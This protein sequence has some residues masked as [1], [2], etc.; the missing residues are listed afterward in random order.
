MSSIFDNANL[1]VTR[2]S[3]AP[4]S[5]TVRNIDIMSDTMLANQALRNI[6]AK[7]QQI[8]QE[9]NE[10]VELER[11]NA[12]D[13]INACYTRELTESQFVNAIDTY[14]KTCKE[15]CFKTI[16]T[17]LYA[18]SLL[19]DDDFVTEH[20][21]DIKTLISD[22]VDSRGGMKLLDESISRTNSNLLKKIKNICIETAS[23]VSKRKIKEA[24]ETQDVSLLNFTMTEDEHETFEYKK[25]E[26]SPDEIASLVKDKVLTVI[27]DE[28]NRQ[29]REDE[30]KTAIEEELKDDEEVVDTQTAKE[31][32]SR[33]IIG[34][35]VVENTTLFNA[36]FRNACNEAFIMN[37][38]PD[39]SSVDNTSDD[40]NTTEDDVNGYAPMDDEN[41]DKREIDMD[42]IFTEAVSQYTLMEMLNTLKLEDYSYNNIKSLIGNLVKPIQNVK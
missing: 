30:L 24:Q 41:Y 22:Y 39:S 21:N 29:E 34:K 1:N 37:N 36:I 19:I 9:A 26:I 31:A 18:K 14:Q 12:Q 7:D 2:H 27:K 13:R 23:E 3:F 32:L 35:S 11:Q 17:E 33:I 40:V 5:D 8:I 38:D 16:L 15:Y 4:K 25:N 6:Q 10:R 20:A 42:K 28:K